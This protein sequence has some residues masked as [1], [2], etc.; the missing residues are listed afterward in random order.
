M[1]R[2]RKQVWRRILAD[3]TATLFLVLVAT[4]AAVVGASGGGVLGLGS[5][6]FAL[7]VVIVA[8][9]HSISRTPTPVFSSSAGAYW[10]TRR[11]SRTE[12]PSY[13]V[14]QCVAAIAATLVVQALVDPASRLGLLPRSSMQTMTDAITLGVDSSLSFM[15]MFVLLAVAADARVAQRI[16]PVAVGLTVGFCVLT[17]GLLTSPSFNPPHAWGYIIVGASTAHWIYWIAP[18][19]AMVAAVRCHD[20]LRGGFAPRYVVREPRGFDRSTSNVVDD[21]RRSAALGAGHRRHRAHTV[22]RP[23]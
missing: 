5:V 13:V 22:I 15:L 9:L 12:V 21:T 20:A 6:V 1:A 4:A 7:V 18:I 16:A 14:A 10:S 3:S 23:A 17:G 19:V 8:L 2:D 11:A